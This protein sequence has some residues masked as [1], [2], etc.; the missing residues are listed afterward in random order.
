MAAT[1]NSAPVTVHRRNDSKYA[2][3]DLW[4]RITGEPSLSSSPSTN[5]SFLLSDRHPLSRSAPVSPR[6]AEVLSPKIEDVKVTEAEDVQLKKEQP[7]PRYA[8]AQYGR[9][10]HHPKLKQPTSDQETGHLR[11]LAEKRQLNCSARDVSLG[12]HGG[13]NITG[14][15]H[16]ELVSKLSKALLLGSSNGNLHEMSKS[17]SSDD[18]FSSPTST[19]FFPDPT[20]SNETEEFNSANQN[21]DFLGTCG[22]TC[23]EIQQHTQQFPEV[24]PIQTCYF[25]ENRTYGELEPQTPSHSFVVCSDTQLGISSKNREWETELEYSRRAIRMINAMDPPPKFVCVCGDLIDMEYTFEERKGYKDGFGSKE[26]CD[27]IQDRQNKD[28]QDVWRGLREDVAIC[29]LVSLY[30]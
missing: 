30:G 21:D 14:Q 26:E 16:Q 28:F 11:M 6:H 5:S 3:I 7:V 2:Q 9:T 13:V 10:L 18:N 24:A 27:E 19:L 17:G 4:N 29:C 22:L 20:F 25:S 23:T 1:S 8:A 12:E 15:S